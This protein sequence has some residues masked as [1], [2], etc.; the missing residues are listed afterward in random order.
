MIGMK[1]IA[2]LGL[3]SAGMAATLVW[4]FLLANFTPLPIFLTGIL[5]PLL[6]ISVW[7]E[8]RQPDSILLATPCW[9]CVGGMH[10]CSH[11]FAIVGAVRL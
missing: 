5:F 10:V 8:T 6:E 4:S 2:S 9:V 11:S 7:L 1:V 3:L